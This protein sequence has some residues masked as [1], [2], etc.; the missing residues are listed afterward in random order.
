[1]KARP[2]TILLCLCCLLLA[3]CQPE[4]QSGSGT[5]SEE[6]VSTVESADLD[7][8][9]P[10]TGY[11]LPYQELL[12]KVNAQCPQEYPKVVTPLPDA[13]ELA[14]MDA[15]SLIGML[16]SWNPVL[17]MEAANA[18]GTRSAEVIP[19][20]RKGTHSAKNKIR[21]GSA[22]ALAALC[23]NLPAEQ[24]P[25]DLD[26]DFIRLSTDDEHEVR[27][28]ALSA[29]G[30]LTPKTRAT[31]LAVLAMCTDPNEYL[32]QDAKVS[33][34]KHFAAYT[35]PIEDIEAGLKAAMGG[36]LPNGKGHIVQII[37]KLKPE[38]QKRFIPVLLEHVAWWPDRDTMF[39]AGGQ[40]QAIEMLTG[41]GD[42][43]V[44][45]LLPDAMGKIGRGEGLFNVCL[46]AM[47][48]F[49]SDAKVLVPRLKEIQVELAAKGREAK[50]RPNR[51]I[52]AGLKKLEQT[53]KHIESL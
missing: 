35:L 28:A 49:G 26:D 13:H 41:F 10:P 30:I 48:A 20:L 29:L 11:T 14:T 45:E 53:I 19:G 1:M 33:L 5:D 40:Q 31:T 25:S 37:S 21:A 4:K 22:T 17:R 16:D 32:A 50:I 36:P 18:L 38:D 23:K 39:A 42:K 24:L 12:D 47:L 6:R 3:A 15:A 43:R 46:D 2:L 27:V 7:A 51:D 9:N 8:P 34:N 52:E 44:L